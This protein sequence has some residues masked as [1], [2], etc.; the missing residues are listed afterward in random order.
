MPQKR[1]AGKEKKNES[2]QKEK[3][4]GQK[5]TK[6]KKGKKDKKK[7]LSM[8]RA[9]VYS[10]CYHATYKQTGDKEQARQSG[11]AALREVFGNCFP[12]IIAPLEWG[13]KAKLGLLPGF[14]CLGTHSLRLALHLH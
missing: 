4:D 8:E 5:E 10:R 7:E 12:K 3:K 2:G 11:Q 1:P 13:Q 14:S 6:K 9:C